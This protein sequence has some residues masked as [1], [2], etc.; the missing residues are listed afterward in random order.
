MD[1]F[2]HCHSVVATAAAEGEVTLTADRLPPLRSALPAEFDGPGDHWSPETLFVGAVADCFILTF[3]AVAAASKLPWTSLRCVAVG[4]L[5]RVD[6]VTQFTGVT[7]R[8]HLSLPAGTQLDRARHALEKAERACV[9][10]N[11]LKATTR[12]ETEIE[13]AT[14]D[15]ETASPVYAGAWD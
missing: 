8:A 14:D 3:R 11:S 12:V 5:D 9:I 15:V 1:A 2:P 6:R 13:L 4:T 10:A 7:V